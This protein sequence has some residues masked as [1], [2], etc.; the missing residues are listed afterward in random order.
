MTDKSVFI[1]IRID[2]INPWFKQNLTVLEG[3]NYQPENIRIVYSIKDSVYAKTVARE[4]KYNFAKSKYKN[5][6]AYIEPMD[7]NLRIFGPSMGSVIFNDWK[8]IF[9]EDYF[10]LFDSDIVNAPSYLIKELMRVN[11]PIVAPYI[12]IYGNGRFYS[13]WEFRHGGRMFSPTEPPGSGLM[14][15][16]ELDSVGACMLVNGEVFKSIPFSDPYPTVTFCYT[17]YNRGY[18]TVG[19]PYV[20]ILHENL[21]ARGVYHRPLPAQF[22]GYPVDQGFASYFTRVKTVGTD[23]MPLTD[24]LLNH[25]NLVH[26]EY[27]R[28]SDETATALFNN[29]PIMQKEKSLQWSKNI[30]RFYNFYFT[31]DPMKLLYYYY[32][33]PLP[34]WCEIEVSTACNFKCKVCELTYWDQ[35]Q[36]FMSFDQFKSIVDQFPVLR[37]IGTTGIGESFLNPDHRKQLRYIREKNPD[38]YVEFFD[39]FYLPDK[40]TLQEWVDYSYDK[41]YFSTDGATKEV[42][43]DNRHG[44]NYE[45]VMDNI[46]LFDKLKKDAGKHYPRFCVHYIINKTNI[47]EADKMIDVISDLGVDVWFIQYTKLLHNYP[48]I[49]GLQV[50]IPPALLEKI[51]T[52]AKDKNIEVRFN[53]NTSQVM[54]PSYVCS[55]WNQP[56]IFVDGTLIPCCACNEGNERNRQI[57]EGMGN[58]FEQSLSDIWN[59]PRY[60]DLKKK[61]F[62]GKVFDA[63]KP[64]PIANV[65]CTA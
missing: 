24:E 6:E 47:H 40:D 39:Q 44:S 31:R 46:V 26:D 18:K 65:R 12:Y 23:I 49:S 60:A 15:P 63:C 45:R 13:T 16:V 14:V 17:A 59:G 43:E 1:G 52:K 29:S 64:C 55:A 5:I 32:V 54:C 9:K 41:I 37:Q 8:K 48:E 36:R 51:K 25:L 50:D 22:G 11:Q 58:I 53:V 7:K 61:L 21:G 27:V 19:L 28:Y 42:Y 34:E 30:N 62:T 20:H 33:N 38:T 2:S 3:L 10:M 57:K 4:I 35:P 56:F